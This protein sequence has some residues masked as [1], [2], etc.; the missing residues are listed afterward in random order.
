M[1][2]LMFVFGVD[3]DGVVADFLSGL[4]PIAEE[5][6]G[7]PAGSLPEKVTYDL[8]EWNLGPTGGY[9]A[10]HRFAVTER[11]L[12]EH[13]EPIEGAPA[14]LR[15]LSEREVR[16]RIITHRLF[17]PYFHQKAVQQTIKWLDH[18]G[19]PYWDLCFMK[20]KAAVGANVYIEDAPEN[21][22]ALRADGHN[23]IAFANSTNV[24]VDAPRAETWNEVEELVIRF[25]EK[26][27]KSR[28]VSK[29][30]SGV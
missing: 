4:K 9:D 21:I 24:G 5:W 17:I 18:H 23:T 7:V 6:Q 8:P 19:I 13:L 26:W 27:E 12:F 30:L 25:K 16:I 29:R 28:P 2:D 10:L 14:A 20:D 22:K 1:A 3:L 15:R 11:G